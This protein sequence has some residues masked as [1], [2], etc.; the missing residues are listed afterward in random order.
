M[1]ENTSIRQESH[2]LTGV[3]GTTGKCWEYDAQTSPDS[4]VTGVHH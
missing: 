2:V 4:R 3:V 1:K